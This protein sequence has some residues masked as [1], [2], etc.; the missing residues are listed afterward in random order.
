[1][2]S[3]DQQQPWNNVLAELWRRATEGRKWLATSLVLL[4]VIVPSVFGLVSFYS[5]AI[6]SAIEHL[7]PRTTVISK[8]EAN[9][10]NEW[11]GVVAYFA[12]EQAALEQLDTFKE[13]YE[14]YET[15]KRSNGV[16]D[17]A[18]WRDDIVVARDPKASGRWIIAIDFYYGPS[19]EP[20][21]S[22]E[23]AR[24]ARL[25]D[26]TAE[27]QNTY[28]KMFVSSRALCYSQITFERTYGKIYPPQ[29]P[30]LDRQNSP[31]VPCAE[32]DT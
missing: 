30:K 6:S 27:A 21:V 10:R 22:A 3:D 23:L 28:Q 25:G 31:Y 18:L 8:D 16:N 9:L 24:V 4:A 11:V 15:V 32:L 12:S 20:V 2:P 14:K 29:E 13:L 7:S 5:S 19:S 26:G 17:Y 1:M